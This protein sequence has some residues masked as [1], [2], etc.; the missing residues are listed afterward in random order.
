MIIIIISMDRS[1][2]LN[3]T[4]IIVSLTNPVT[5]MKD[6]LLFRFL[7][8]NPFSTIRQ[9]FQ[10]FSSIAVGWGLMAGAAALFLVERIPNFRRD[11]FSL[12]PLERYS[13]Y[14]VIEAEQQDE[15]DGKT[16]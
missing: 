7:R 12:L 2:M 6:S 15:Q 4:T 14:R 1:C 13:E 9:Q 11:F 3:I 5:I 8:P 16:D 10:S